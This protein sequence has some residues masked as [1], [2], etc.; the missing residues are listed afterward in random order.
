MEDWT[1]KTSISVGNMSGECKRCCFHP[2]GRCSNGYDCRPASIA[3]QFCLYDPSQVNITNKVRHG[4]NNFFAVV[5]EKDLL[6]TSHFARFQLVGFFFS[7]KNPCRFCHFDHDKRKR[8]G[9]L[10]DICKI[11]RGLETGDASC[12]APR[13][14]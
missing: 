11:T 7:T 9:G 3:G 6:T 2:K 1:K 12:K 13:S 5:T 14:P 4:T 10:V 8:W